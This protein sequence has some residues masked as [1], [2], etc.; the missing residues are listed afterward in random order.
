MSAYRTRNYSLA[1]ALLRRDVG[2]ALLVPSALSP[3]AGGTI[4]GQITDSTDS[5]I[6]GADVS[7]NSRKTVAKKA[8]TDENGSFTAAGLLQGTTP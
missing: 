2:H 8:S 5:A 1:L 7:I 3:N 4:K 6:P